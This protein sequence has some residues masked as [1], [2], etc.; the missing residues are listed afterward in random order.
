MKKNVFGR[1]FRR[2][3]NERKA[4]LKGL[5]SSLVLE[6]RI[7]TTEQ[8]AKSIKGQ[9]EKL[10]TKARKENASVRIALDKYL[11][12]KAAEKL[13]SDIAPRFLSRP[14][15]YTRIVRIGKRVTDSASMV[16]LEW[17]EGPL[18]K[19]EKVVKVGKVAKGRKQTGKS[20][21]ASRQASSKSVGKDK[22]EVKTKAKM[23]S[24][25]KTEPTQA[26]TTLRAGKPIVA[27]RGRSKSL[28]GSK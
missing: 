19:V 27:K 10:V 9:V 1:N 6:E 21:V 14:G 15:G 2:D 24:V 13:I 16:F 11:I 8:K 17:V 4:L 5:M 3:T 12:P 20:Q 23:S 25:G 28:S 22:P 26:R 18:E 7:K